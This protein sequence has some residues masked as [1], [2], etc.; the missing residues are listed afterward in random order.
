MHQLAPPPHG[1]GA[2]VSAG[3]SAAIAS[4]QVGARVHFA[5]HFHE[6]ALS[7]SLR[8]ELDGPPMQNCTDAPSSSFAGR[9]GDR[10]A[11]RRSGCFESAPEGCDGRCGFCGG[12][13]VRSCG[14]ERPDKR[15]HEVRWRAGGQGRGAGEFDRDSSAQLHTRCSECRRRLLP[16]LIAFL[17]LPFTT[18]DR[19]R[20][21]PSG[22]SSPRRAKLP[23]GTPPQPQGVPRPGGRASPAAAAAGAAALA[24]RA[25]GV[26]RQQG[27]EGDPWRGARSALLSSSGAW[28]CRLRA[29]RQ[30]WRA[31]S[32]RPSE[33]PWSEPSG[34]DPPRA[35]PPCPLRTQGPVRTTAGPNA[36]PARLEAPRCPL[37]DRRPHAQSRSV[38]RGPWLTPAKAFPPRSV[39]P[40][41]CNNSRSSSSSPVR[42]ATS[43]WAQC[44]PCHLR[45]LSL[46]RVQQRPAP[47]RMLRR[48]T[49]MSRIPLSSWR[50]GLSVGPPRAKARELQ[51]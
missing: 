34:E 45:P 40:A 25:P 19:R 50:G 41:T 18:S 24:A 29:A 5:V 42:S 47:A 17:P 8:F 10:T 14:G 49:M 38:E 22:L 37:G 28:G 51:G 35:P 39:R 23:R 26:H 30:T 20:W 33:G 11:A 32:A 6:S 44:V 16:L 36:H 27:A 2:G 3:V 15:T 1:V 7:Q 12:G 13:L 4:P 9:W 46:D 43:H 48:R 31:C 21:R